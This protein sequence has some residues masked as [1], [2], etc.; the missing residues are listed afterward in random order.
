MERGP[1]SSALCAW[2]QAQGVWAG[3]PLLVA[4]AAARRQ[5]LPFGEHLARGTVLT[6]ARQGGVC[7][8]GTAAPQVYHGCLR[9]G[10]VCRER[11]YHENEIRG[12]PKQP[13][14]T[15]SA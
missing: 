1:L 12:A 10:V 13:L 15:V 2:A 3:P 7:G 11:L 9:G 14:R 4:W 5:E 6:F 8:A